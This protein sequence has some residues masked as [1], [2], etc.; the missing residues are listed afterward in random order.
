MISYLYTSRER[1]IH[2]KPSANTNYAVVWRRTTLAY[3]NKQLYT[4]RWWGS[5]TILTCAAECKKRCFNLFIFFILMKH[6]SW[7][8]RD[9]FYVCLETYICEVLSPSWLADLSLALFTDWL[10]L[11]KFFTALGMKLWRLKEKKNKISIS[12]L[13][14]Q[15]TCRK[16][17]HR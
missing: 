3:R 2:L 11:F 4:F 9:F 5:T 14:V 6:V 1:N 16:W 13:N 15:S 10:I 7:G 12:S 8:L 17:N